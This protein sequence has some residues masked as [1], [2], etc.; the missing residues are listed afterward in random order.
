MRPCFCQI[1]VY[2]YP[3]NMGTHLHSISSR[4]ARRIRAKDKGSV[5]TPGDFLDLGSRA[6]V[7]QALL[8]HVR[9]GLVR[10]IG[11]GLY[12]LPQDHHALGRLSPSTDSIAQAVTRRT[13]TTLVPSG[14]QA[15]NRLG[16]SDQVPMRSVYLTDGSSRRIQVGKTTLILRHASSRVLRTKNPISALVIQALRWIGRNQ[17]NQDTLARL[18]RKLPRQVRLALVKDAPHAPGWIADIFHRLAQESPI[19]IGTYD[20]TAIRREKGRNRRAIQQASPAQKAAMQL[21][22]SLAGLGKDDLS[23]NLSTATQGFI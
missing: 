21:S 5:F 19:K 11:R 15:A 7:D 13:K 16:L 2:I 1:A 6:A 18:R 8:R 4:I 20:A 14:A 23:F 10:K 17:V 3:T 12:D 22:H 9:D